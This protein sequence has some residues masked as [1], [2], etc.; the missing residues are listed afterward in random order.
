MPDRAVLLFADQSGDAVTIEPDAIVRKKD[1]ALVQTNF[2]QSRTP[3]GTETCERFKIARRMLDDWHGDVSIELFRRI[4][5]AT[6]Q[7]GGAST[8]YSNIYD[9][10]ARVMYLYH[11]HNF[12]NVVGIDLAEELR[13]GARKL[14][15]PSL[16][17]R[18]YAWEAHVRWC[19]SQQK[20]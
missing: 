12:E 15:I 18:T 8:Q 20:K 9:L 14:E 11:F 10:K 17:P 13:K 6:H 3:A 2:Y 7:E 5:A 19:E 1:W 16:F 4:L